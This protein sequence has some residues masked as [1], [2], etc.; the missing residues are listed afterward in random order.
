MSRLY[1]LN[2]PDGAIAMKCS[3]YPSSVSDKQWQ[4]MSRFVDDE[5]DRGRPRTD[6]RLIIDA[7]WYWNRSGCPWRYIPKEVGPWQTVYRAY[8][9]VD[10]H[11]KQHVN[12]E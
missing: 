1:F 2:F 9:R 6:R 4:L 8:Q 3:N 12:F 11:K 5:K 10:F 7:I